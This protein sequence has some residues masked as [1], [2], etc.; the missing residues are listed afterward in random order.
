MASKVD[1]L[2]FAKLRAFELVVRHGTLQV[3]AARLN[4]TVSAVSTQIKRLEQIVGAEL[5]VR[6]PGR[7]TITAAGERFAADTRQLIEAAERALTRLDETVGHSGHVDLSLGADYAWLFMPKIDSFSARHRAITTTIRIHRGT[8]AMTALQK[9]QV[10]FCIGAFLRRPKGVRLTTVATST[11]SMIFRGRD[12]ADVADAASP[13]AA[14]RDRLIIAPRSA[15]VRARVAKWPELKGAVNYLE[16]PTCHTAIDLVKRESG[17][18]IVHT[19]CLHQAETTGIRAIDL[20]RGHGVEQVIVAYKASTL[21]QSIMKD[22]LE[23]LVR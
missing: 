21:K 23:W 5:F 11:M 1:A 12:V 20:G 7:L 13:L 9:G 22:L 10:D 4:L 17:P 18:A 6:T 3:A 16:C 19:L 14:V 2:D 8:E 15:T